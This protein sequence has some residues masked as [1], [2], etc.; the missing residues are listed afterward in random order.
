MQQRRRR[1][2]KALEELRRRRQQQEVEERDRRP[3]AS[4]IL[5]RR[6]G[7]REEDEGQGREALG[8]RLSRHEERSDGARLFHVADWRVARL[9]LA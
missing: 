6:L 9:L 4:P 8:L 5:G 7:Q 3:A 2:Q 1:E